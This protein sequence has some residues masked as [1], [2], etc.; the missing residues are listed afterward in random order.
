MGAVSIDIH[1]HEREFVNI[2]LSDVN[3][4]KYLLQFRD[5][6]DSN[7]ES[8]QNPNYNNAGNTGSLNQELIHLY[9][10]LD[11]LIEGC[12]FT[13]SNLE[14]IKLVSRGYTFADI[15]DIGEFGTS[16]RSIA[17]KF[18]T[19]C[20]AI[21]DYNDYLW[22][23]WISDRY[24]KSEKKQCSK[25]KELLPITKRFFSPDTRNKDGFHSICR[26]CR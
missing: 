2:N 1:K 13:P 16:A 6:V 9:A 17:K 20:K 23:R 11:E 10:Y 15:E 25:C 24:N 3:V 12:Q 21:T 4:I 14:L 5:K 7:F 8:S 19:I 26:K 18:D 22:A